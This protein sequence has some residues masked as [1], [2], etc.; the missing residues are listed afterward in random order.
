MARQKIEPQEPAPPREAESPLDVP[1]EADSLAE[2]EVVAGRGADSTIEFQPRRV[3][4]ARGLSALSYRDFRLFWGGQLVS[5]TGTWMQIVAQSWLVL[6]LSNSPFI[7]GLLS[8][9][10]F[11]PILTLSVLGG[12]AADRLPKRQLLLATQVASLALAFVLGALT[13][14]GLVTIGTVL[15]LAVLLG[16][17]NAVDM[18][19]R[20]AFVVELV[21]R[22][23]LSNA[24]ALNST[25]FNAA[26][27][28]GPAV[29]GLAIGVIG[30]AG[31]FYLNG[32]SFLA[33]IGALLAIEA[34]RAP[35]SRGE[36]PGRVRD[37][38]KEGLAYVTRTPL[39]WLIVLLVALVGTFGMNLNVLIPVLARDV[40]QVGATGFGL[41]TSAAG[42]G[43]LAAAVLLAFVGRTPRPQLLLVSA[44]ILGLTE[45]ALA[46]VRQFNLALILL[47]GTGFAMIFFTT[48]ANTVLQQATPDALRGRVMSVYTTVFAGT[49]PLGSLFIG[50]LAEARGLGAAFLAGGAI[51][52]AAVIAVFALSRRYTMRR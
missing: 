8:A 17:V 49:T 26:R 37:D 13:Q 42:L 52:V 46:P 44:G 51:S 27:L 6:Q 21:D 5:L 39:I 9:L 12:V 14:T 18:P 19:T 36:E 38:L 31:A 16:L 7:L 50:W 4:L 35:L 3:G 40:L 24:I 23:D 45:I 11:L 2:T 1:G 47:A 25:A 20:Q 30:I 43:S 33:V 15:A 29:A 34:G 48:L 22:K 10:Q 28:V 41:L 32:L